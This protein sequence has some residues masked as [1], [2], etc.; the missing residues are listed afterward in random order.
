VELYWND[1]TSQ[2]RVAQ[3]DFMKT[4]RTSFGA[5]FA[6]AKTYLVVTSGLTTDFKPTKKSEVYSIEANRWTAGKDLVVARRAHS[7]CEVAAGAYIYVFGG[8]AEDGVTFLDTI[9]RA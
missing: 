9:E 5:C 1:L 4:P 8:Q 6:K 2:W 7:M 3:K